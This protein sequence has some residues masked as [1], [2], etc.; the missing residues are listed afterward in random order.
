MNIRTAIDLHFKRI[1][2][3]S[4]FNPILN[5]LSG[6]KKRI[7]LALVDFFSRVSSGRMCLLSSSK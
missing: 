6:Y 1:Y 4:L 7:L 5:M 2:D 3:F